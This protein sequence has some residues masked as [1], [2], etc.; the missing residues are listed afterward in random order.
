MGVEFSFPTLMTL[1]ELL[2]FLAWANENVGSSGTV[3]P[4]AA[5]ARLSRRA[6]PV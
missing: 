3:S 5:S 6:E 2:S 1:M 4:A